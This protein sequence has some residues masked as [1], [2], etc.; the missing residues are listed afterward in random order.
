MKTAGLILDQYD[1][2]PGRK[3]LIK[4]ASSNPSSDIFKEEIIPSED[5]KKLSDRQFALLT[6]DNKGN[7]FRRYPVNSPGHTKLSAAF[8]LQN[9]NKLPEGIQK[10]TA[11]RFIEASKKHNIKLPGIFEN[12]AQ[13][14]KVT[15]ISAESIHS[16]KFKNKNS[17]EIEIGINNALDLEKVATSYERNMRNLTPY[18]RRKIAIELTKIAKA[19]NVKLTKPVIV[20]YS[21]SKFCPYWKGYVNLRK[22]YLKDEEPVKL[23]DEFLEKAASLKPYKA[24]EVLETFDT[25]YGLDRFYGTLP[26]AYYSMIGHTKSAEYKYGEM[27]ESRIRKLAENKNILKGHFSPDIIEEFSKNP[28]QIFQSLPTPHKDIM[29]DLS[30]SL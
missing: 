17:P 21:S 14:E 25:K 16:I 30:H 5:L 23:L 29:I 4:I 2:D 19:L 6:I 1:K 7:K 20:K 9:H 13:G 10:E 22:D 27:D 24:A 28:V 18:N 26:D 11:S 12:I 3:G 15:S 8:F